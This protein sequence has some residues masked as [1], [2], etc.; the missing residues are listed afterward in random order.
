M[1]LSLLALAGI[2]AASEELQCGLFL[3]PST[4]PG[5]GRA[6]VSGLDYAP[7]EYIETVPTLTID[8]ATVNA[9]QLQS[10]AF[11]TGLPD[12]EMVIFGPG[13]IYNHH[14]DRSIEHFWVSRD[15]QD[16]YDFNTSYSTFTKDYWKTTRGVAV[17]DEIFNYYGGDWFDRFEEKGDKDEGGD[18]KATESRI[19]AQRMSADDLR[20]YGHCVTDVEIL[21]STLTDVG[22]GLFARRDY[23]AGEVVSI[24]PVLNLPRSVVDGSANKSMLMNYC[25]AVEGSEMVLHPLN[26]APLMNHNKD[27]NVQP[28]WY[29]WGPAV[30]GVASAYNQGRGGDILDLAKTLSSTP[31]ELFSASFAQLDLAYIALKPIKTG[32]E[33]WVDYGDTWVAAWEKH[34]TATAAAAAD[35]TAAAAAS[36]EGAIVAPAPATASGEGEGVVVPAPA[37]VPP[38]RHYMGV[39]QGL[40]PAH[41]LHPVSTPA[42]P[43]PVSATPAPAPPAD[44]PEPAPDRTEL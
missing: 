12:L 42:A 5:A 2:A 4:I 33:I 6:V 14:K 35:A 26:Y 9:C 7:G 37:P 3:V 8:K 10:Y 40:Y 22:A 11:N 28:S 30:R 1:M 32:E 15:L 41:W 43:A 36:G 44:V 18:K 24:S 16:P 31:Q 25:Y 38:F 23:E 39:P 17:G 29:D 19:D 21:P 13:N 20:W 27:A 34:A